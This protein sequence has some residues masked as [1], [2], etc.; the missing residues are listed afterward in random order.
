M[1]N[2]ALLGIGLYT[3]TEAA[4]LLRVDPRT[5][6]WW[7]EGYSP[8]SQAGRRASEPVI[9]RDLVALEGEPLLTFT[10]LLELHMVALFRRENVSLQTIRAAA[11]KAAQLFNT[12]HPFVVKQ[13]ETDGRHIFA[14][15]EDEGIAGRTQQQ[16]ITDLNLSQMVISSIARLFFLNIEYQDFEPI[17]YWPMGRDGRVVL[18]PQRSFGKPIDARS[19]VPTAALYTMARSGESLQS[20]ADWYEIEVEAVEAAVNFEH[21]LKAA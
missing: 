7:A 5:L 18:D 2:T 16:M 20:V 19:G 17:R 14:T 12:R 21:S 3:M 11:D 10:D 8:V 1:I 6:Q 9:Q 13:F 15:L 4:R